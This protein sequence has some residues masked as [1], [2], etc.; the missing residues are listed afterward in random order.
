V[1]YEV[2]VAAGGSC[3]V[4]RFSAGDPWQLQVVCAHE[5]NAPAGAAIKLQEKLKRMM[6]KD[7]Q[8][9]EQMELS[10]AWLGAELGFTFTDTVPHL[11]WEALG[12]DW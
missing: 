6:Q 1:C 10:L 4:S 7:E 8:Q 12:V 5:W 3:E 11:L 9:Q 2:S